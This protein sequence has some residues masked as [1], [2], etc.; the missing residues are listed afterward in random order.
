MQRKNIYDILKEAK[1]DLEKEYA[2]IYHMFYR[3]EIFIGRKYGSPH[4]IINDNFNYLNKNLVKRC[5]NIYDFDETYKFSFSD[6]PYD[7][8]INY[9]I[10]FCEYILNFIF[11]SP[12]NIKNGLQSLTDHIES[13]MNDIGYT[14][15]MKDNI[16][17]YV[18]SNP[19][20]LAVAEIV[21]DKISYSILEYNHH[22][23]KGDLLNK[24]NILKHLADDIEPQKQKLKVI[25][26]KTQD[27]LFFLLNHFIRH[28][29]DGK[30]YIQQMDDSKKE[31]AYD[32]AY[33][34]YLCAKLLLQNE[35][36]N[37]RI[38]PIKD[39]VKAKNF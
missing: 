30:N 15:A 10:S 23:L 32:D 31:Q 14:R 7:F 35:E 39:S 21:D 38:K 4:K 25:D 19:A 3:N 13:C 28:N 36:I 22:K 9:L 17:I 1:I 33:Q 37:Q 20:A 18:E 16:A 2:R 26:E 6:S 5:L 11:S 27:N 29:N 34:L 24:K 12:E 8:D